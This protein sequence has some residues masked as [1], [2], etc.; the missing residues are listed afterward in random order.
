MFHLSVFERPSTLCIFSHIR[1]ARV[2]TFYS[3]PVP[4]LYCLINFA[5]LYSR[6]CTLFSSK[7]VLRQKGVTISMNVLIT[8]VNGFI[9]RHAVKAF[10][11]SGFHVTGVD[12]QSRCH[13]VDIAYVQGDL[14][15]RSCFTSLIEAGPYD[16]VVHLAANIETYTG[17]PLRVNALTAYHA[18]Q[19]A[20]QVGCK[21][22]LHLSSIPVIGAPPNFPITEEHQ[23]SPQTAYHI[24]KYAAEQVVMLPEFAMMKRYNLRIASPI[25]PDMPMRFPRIMLENAKAGGLLE[26]YGT[27]SRV[28]NYIDARDIAETLIKVINANA[29]PG[30]YLLGGESHSNIDVA[31]ISAAV[32]NGG[33]IVFSDKPDPLDQERWLINDRKARI[34][35][36]H[37]PQYSLEQT[38]KDMLM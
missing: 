33:R 16:C 6:A 34:A 32:A 27:G 5:M 10:C 4:V 12:I 24:S 22:F 7:F 17:S 21:Y 14:T 3:T 35:L 25:G 1:F 13:S 26:I 36:G 31:H 2:R 15:D 20:N 11:A 29:E 37:A 19:T 8:G 30:L 38:L 28:Q 23:V 18:L 9:G